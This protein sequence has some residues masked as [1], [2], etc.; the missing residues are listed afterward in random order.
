MR[1]G[2]ILLVLGSV[3]SACQ[4]G[5]EGPLPGGSVAPTVAGTVP[6]CFANG[7]EAMVAFTRR[8]GSLTATLEDAA[9]LRFTGSPEEVEQ[10]HRAYFDYGYTTFQVEL[11]SEDFVQPTRETFLLED[12]RG[13][14]VSGCPL[15]FTTSPTLVDN[16]YFS[17][18]ALS[19][20]H[21]ITADLCWLRLTRT[22][23]GSTVEWTFGAARAGS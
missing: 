16:R 2:A 1:R 19:F 17:A 23:D 10:R 20:Q 18:F 12:S 15:E 3:L 5:R 21:V 14:R 13:Q 8:A 6:S 7:Q 22:R 11:R 4:G 9:W